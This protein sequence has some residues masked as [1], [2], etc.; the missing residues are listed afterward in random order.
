VVRAAAD[1]W[2]SGYD[3]DR[4]SSLRRAQTFSQLD[5]RC[6]RVA[7]SDAESEAPVAAAERMSQQAHPTANSACLFVATVV[8]LRGARVIV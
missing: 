6:M 8:L 4:L 3:T 5:Q 2:M 1:Q 7:S